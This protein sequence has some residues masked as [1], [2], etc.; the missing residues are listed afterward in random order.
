V[1]RL[2]APMALKEAE[3]AS[4][5]MNKKAKAAA[6]RNAIFVRFMWKSSPKVRHRYHSKGGTAEHRIVFPYCSLP[7][8]TTWGWCCCLGRNPKPG[9][10]AMSAHEGRADFP[11][12]AAKGPLLTHIGH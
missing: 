8:R 5:A 7:L 1:L 3:F 12:L 4:C 11:H 9:A 6:T 2:S 10:E